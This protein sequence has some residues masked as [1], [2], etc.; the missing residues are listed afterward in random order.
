LSNLSSGLAEMATEEF[1]QL[2]NRWCHELGPVVHVD[3]GGTFDD[4]KFMGSLAF[5]YASS[6][7]K[8]VS[9]L[10]P[11]MTSSGRGEI[12]SSCSNGK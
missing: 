10:E 7:E 11:A 8:R 5:L 1:R 4:V 2:S 9:A 6:I 3:V 12:V